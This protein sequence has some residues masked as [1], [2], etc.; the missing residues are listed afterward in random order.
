MPR[1]TA[2]VHTLN[3]SL[4]IGRCLETLYP[5][6]D[7]LIADHGSQDGTVRVAHEYAAKV[8]PVDDNGMLDRDLRGADW[9]LCL[10]A[11]ESLSEAL[12]A[13][14]YEWK[15][16]PAID[17]AFSM[18]LREETVEGW[19]QHSVPQTRLVPASWKS[20][21]GLLPTNHASAVQLAGEVL[22][23]ALP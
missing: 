20:W 23:F 13:S 12:A 5:C 8:I 1:I 9:I 15:L 6:D 2:L 18:F 4:R 16:E 21:D 3:D 22:R 17:S 7:I 11:R 14:L 19:V 10:D